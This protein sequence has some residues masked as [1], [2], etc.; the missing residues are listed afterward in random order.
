MSAV[1][2]FLKFIGWTAVAVFGLVLMLPAALFFCSML[3]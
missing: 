2:G 3:T 1:I